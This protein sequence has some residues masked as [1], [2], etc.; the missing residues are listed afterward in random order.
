MRELAHLQQIFDGWP[1]AAQLR[2]FGAAGDG[3]HF[4]VQIVGQALVQAQLFSAKMLASLK[5]GKVEKTE[6]DWFLHFISE[7]AGENDPGDM[8]FDDLESFYRVRVEGRVLQ[9]SDQGLAHRRSFRV[10]KIKAAIMAAS[11]LDA[12]L[13]ALLLSMNKVRIIR[14]H[15]SYS[16]SPYPEKT[17][18]QGPAPVAGLGH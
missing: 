10:W 4:Q 13:G 17:T 11:P 5:A 1:F 15:D 3:Q 14:R 16:N 2:S 6:V 12:N 18:L 8:G 9:G 7:G